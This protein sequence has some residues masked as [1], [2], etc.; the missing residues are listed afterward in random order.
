M[1]HAPG[2][3]R[4]IRGPAKGGFR[5]SLLAWYRRTAR[6]L[7]WRR[8]PEPYKVWIA[9]IIL[10]QTRVEQGLPYY[11]RF[12]ASFPTLSALASAEEDAVLRVW[13]GLGYYRRA[14]NLHRAA[15]VLAEQYEGRFPT[16]AREWMALPGVGR[17]TAGAIVSI[18]FGEP[19]PVL[20]G[21]VKR[22]LSRL[23]NITSCID[24]TATERALWDEAAA[25]VPRNAP[26]DFNQA[27]ME[28]G[29]RICTPRAPQCAAC[30]VARHCAAL[31]LGV[32]E[33][34]PVRRAK[35]SIPR[36]EAVAA[37]VMKN[38]RYLM[39]KRPSDGLLAGLWEFPSAEVRSGQSHEA[40]L[41]RG[42]KVLL[43]ID[44]EV[45]GMLGVMNHAYS[46]FRVNL[47]AYRCVHIGGKPIPAFH[48]QVKWILRHDFGQ[49]ALPK[50]ARELLPLL[51]SR[52]GKR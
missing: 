23:R 13:E 28:L 35:K 17:Y 30:P 7:P 16:T 12:I 26:G 5:R 49:Y 9:E 37:I 38:G 43:G 20:D 33:E 11:E 19:A 1:I 14:R 50:I 10:Q 46:H 47:S 45:A 8:K 52:T 3:S 42:M 21:N 36:Q 22:V 29:A 51:G 31:A 4:A 40:A 24:D 41:I 48:T 15:K 44:I 18:A 27:M 39:A 25:L 34:R 2:E 32:Q 6:D